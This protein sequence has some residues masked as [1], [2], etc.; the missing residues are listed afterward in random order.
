MWSLR[1]EKRSALV[2][3]CRSLKFPFMEIGFDRPSNLA[4]ARFSV[5]IRKVVPMQ[6]RADDV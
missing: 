2:G 1:S 4:Q 3:L 5:L 6:G